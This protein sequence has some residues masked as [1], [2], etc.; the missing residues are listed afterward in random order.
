MPVKLQLG[1]SHDR[2]RSVNSVFG[3]L[4]RNRIHPKLG[5]LWC[6]TS[7]TSVRAAVFSSLKR[8]LVESQTLEP[9]QVLGF[10]QFFTGFDALYGDPD[11]EL[12]RSK[13]LALD[14]RFSDTSFAGAEAATRDM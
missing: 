13:A 1:L 11:G 6:P 2:F 5:V 8:P 3:E 4:T 14:H 12:S 9:T 10:N 7:R